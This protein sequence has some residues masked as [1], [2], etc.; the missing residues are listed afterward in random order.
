MGVISM[1][2]YSVGNNVIGHSLDIVNADNAVQFWIY[3]S[4]FKETKMKL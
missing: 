2:V 1:T 3:Y 4:L